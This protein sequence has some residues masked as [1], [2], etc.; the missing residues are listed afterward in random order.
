MPDESIDLVFADPPYNLQLKNELVRPDN[1][2]VSA[3]NDDWDKFSSFNDYDLFTKKWLKECKRILKSNGT[4][5]AFCL[6]AIS[7]FIFSFTLTIKEGSEQLYTFINNLW[8]IIKLLTLDLD[9]GFSKP[10]NST[11]PTTL[12]PCS[13]GVIPKPLLEKITGRVKR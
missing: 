9:K 7:C 8:I 10:P 6:K 4:K 12:N 1:S 3:V 2:K 13:I 11:V 5:D